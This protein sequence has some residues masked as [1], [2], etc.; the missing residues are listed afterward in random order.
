M[1]IDYSTFTR[2]KIVEWVASQSLASSSFDDITELHQV[3][4]VVDMH[5]LEDKEL[6][7]YKQ[8]L[9]ALQIMGVYLLV[10]LVVIVHL[11]GGVDLL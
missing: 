9:K 3:M 10:P 11:L 8:Q 7:V 6:V 5:K 1:P 2:E 4:Q